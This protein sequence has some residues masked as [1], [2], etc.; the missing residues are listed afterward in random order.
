MSLHQCYFSFS[1]SS[2]GNRHELWQLNWPKDFL[3]FFDFTVFPI[4][5]KREIL[6][7]QLFSTV[8]FRQNGGC[9]GFKCIVHHYWESKRFRFIPFLSTTFGDFK[10]FF[11]SMPMPQ[12]TKYILLANL[13]VSYPHSSKK[14]K[15]KNP[16]QP[17]FFFSCFLRA[18]IGGFPNMQKKKKEKKRRPQ[19][20]SNKS[21]KNIIYEASLSHTYLEKNFLIQ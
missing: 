18:L 2:E 17:S 1:L 9:D 14:R 6:W 8:W 7:Q 3:C 11:W 19:P 12:K 5:F 15:E 4:F 21:Q 10:N 20:P 16:F 13:S